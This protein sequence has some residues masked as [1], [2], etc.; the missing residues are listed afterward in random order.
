RQKEIPLTK[1]TS[2]LEEREF[3][4]ALINVS[5][6]AIPK[7]YFLDG[8]GGRDIDSEDQVNGGHLFKALLQH[9]SYEVE[10]LLLTSEN[11][12]IPPDC[13]V[14][15]IND[16]TSDLQ[17][18]E[19]VALDTYLRNGGRLLFLFNPS[20]IEQDDVSAQERLKPWLLSRLGVDVQTDIILSEMTGGVDVN[21]LTDFAQLGNYQ[22]TAPNAVEFRGSYHATHPITRNIG[23]ITNLQY[24]RSVVL[25]EPLPDRVVGSSILRTTPDTWGE[26]DFDRL[27]LGEQHRD[28]YEASGPNSIAVA[29]TYQSERATLEGEK[30]SD[31]RVVV[32][33]N[34]QCT[35]NQLVLEAGTADLLLNTIAW[36]TESEDLIAIRPR[37]NETAILRLSLNEQRTIIWISVLGTVQAVILAGIG[38]FLFRR[39]YQ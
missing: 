21:L 30:S 20:T 3:T 16:Y 39:R 1:V 2:R 11:A 15:V 24:L 6:N 19:I 29:M 4:N 34:S 12:S 28:G 8:H 13:A 23:V 18:D 9:E 33:G 35:A 32:I 36:L 26:V 14:L 10:K 17:E 22:D 25:V 27:E 37:G 5:R 31:G 38:T 7:V